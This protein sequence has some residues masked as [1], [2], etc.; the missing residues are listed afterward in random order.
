MSKDKYYD[1]ACKQLSNILYLYRMYE[2]KKPIMLY[3]IQENHVYA[4]QYEG[5]RDEFEKKESRISLEEQ[6][7]KAQK[8][9]EVVV[10]IRDNKEKRLVSFSFEL[11]TSLGMAK[12]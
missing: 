8:D 1:I 10:F 4:H 6:Y 5:F 12:K 2:Q 11:N 3:D 7:E 9:N